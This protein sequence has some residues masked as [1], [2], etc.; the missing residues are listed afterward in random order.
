[1]SKYIQ[2]YANFLKP[3]LHPKRTVRVIIDCSNGTAGIILKQ[4]LNNELRIKNRKL[5]SIIHNSK[6]IILNSKPDGNFPAHG[7]DPLAP[8]AAVQLQREVKKPRRWIGAPNAKRIGA[9]LGIIFDAD[10]DRVF[11][12][13]D[14]GRLVDAHEAGFALMQMFK[15]PFIVSTIAS[16]RL[17]KYQESGIRNQELG[18]MN[19]ARKRKAVYISPVGHYFFKNMMREKRASV[20]LEHSGHFYFK[21][22]FYCDSGIFSAI[23]IINFISALKTDWSEW[24]D[25]LP[26]YHRS[27]EINFSAEGGPASGWPVKIMNKIENKYKR[28]ASKVSKIDGLT[29]E[30]GPPTGGWWFNVRPSNTENLLRLNVET[31]DKKVLT[32][33]LASLKK[34]IT[35]KY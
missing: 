34:L 9:D 29:M 18:N 16:W 17:K 30:F 11:F 19:Q 13:D 25:E 10:G 1:M 4:L 20:G 28:A 31:H 27:G 12:V 26:E 6:F 32:K 2:E 7:P 35:R 15:P 14:R 24:L 5:N 33:E 22:F 3:F 23:Q 21:D 8:G